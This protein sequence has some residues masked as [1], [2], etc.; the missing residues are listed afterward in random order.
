Y[1]KIVLSVVVMILILVTLIFMFVSQRKFME[2][3]KLSLAFTIPVQVY[4]GW[5]SVASI[6]NITALLVHFKWN[7]FGISQPIWAIIMIII[8]GILGLIMLF[9]FNAIAYSLVIVWAYIGIIIKRNLSTPVYKEIIITSSIM[10]AILLIA[11]IRSGIL[12]IKKNS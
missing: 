9:K 11:V 6:A 12:L 7:G 2:N 4:L 1:E 5:I 8:G 10:I 3:Q